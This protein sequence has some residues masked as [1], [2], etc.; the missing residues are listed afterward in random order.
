MNQPIASASAPGTTSVVTSP[1]PDFLAIVVSSTQMA[2]TTRVP[3]SVQRYRLSPHM[4]SPPMQNSLRSMAAIVSGDPPTPPTG[5]RVPLMRGRK[6]FQP[7]SN[8]RRHGGIARSPA[9]HEAVIAAQRIGKTPLRPAQQGQDVAEAIRGQAPKTLMKAA[10]APNRAAPAAMLERTICQG[11]RARSRASFS[12]SARSFACSSMNF[13]V[14]A[15]ERRTR[16]TCSAMSRLLGAE[17]L[18]IG[19]VPQSGRGQPLGH[20]R[21]MRERWSEVK[22][23]LQHGIQESK[24]KISFITD[25]FTG[26]IAQFKS[27]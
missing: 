17:V 2:T 5:G 14:S 4:N 19:V 26:K 15:F 22:I 12:A 9:P 10:P 3:M 25:A 7:R 13:W 20:V 8:V 18:A 21:N 16:A 24:A 1:S 23:P 11:A 27:V 6:R